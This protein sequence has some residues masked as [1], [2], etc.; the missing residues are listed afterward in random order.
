MLII[1]LHFIITC[2][3]ELGKSNVSIQQKHRKM[4]CCRPSLPNSVLSDF[5]FPPSRPWKSAVPTHQHA[6]PPTTLPRE[7]ALQQVP[8]HR[9]TPGTRGSSGRATRPLPHGE[10]CH[11]P[12]PSLHRPR[13]KGLGAILHFLTSRAAGP[14]GL[15]QAAVLRSWL[16]K[17]FPNSAWFPFEQEQSWF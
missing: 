4:E 3:L 13:C 2:A 12:C 5:T 1:L 10:A 8:A 6:P 9:W 17:Y 15:P 14:D 11:S 7:P 16:G